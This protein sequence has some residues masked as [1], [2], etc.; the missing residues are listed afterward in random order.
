MIEKFTE[1]KIMDHVV[2]DGVT[3]ECR[4]AGPPAD[5]GQPVLVFL[6][7]GLG[8]VGQWKDFPDL[9]AKRTGLPTLIFSRQGYGASDPIPLPRPVSF[10]HHEGQSVLPAL[11]KAVGIQD[12]ILVGHSDG[13]SISLIHAGS[14]NAS[15]V[16]GLILEAPHVFVEPETLSGIRDAKVAYEAGGLR[17]GLARYHGENVDCA[18]WGWNGVWLNPDF[19]RWNIEE[20]LPS[21]E[22][23]T[24]VIQGELDEYGTKAQVDAIASNVSG[25]VETVMIPDCG[26]APHAQQR[27][28]VA[29]AMVGF[30]KGI[31]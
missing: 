8:S 6:H 30:V 3:L 11:L 17:D 22:V 23:P 21:V 14:G 24:M 25:P 19:E 12:A 18:F 7:E 20:F 31:I 15:A 1:S 10:M 13:A 29:D 26:H 28:K 27:D 2:V 16:R 4:W 5:G 9:I